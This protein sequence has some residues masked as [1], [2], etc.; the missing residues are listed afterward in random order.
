[1]ESFEHDPFASI[2]APTFDLRLAG[3]ARVRLS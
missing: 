3:E 1:L 2:L